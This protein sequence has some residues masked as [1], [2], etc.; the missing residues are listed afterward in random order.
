M[1][2]TDTTKT[3]ALAPTETAPQEPSGTVP[4]TQHAK[5]PSPP[6]TP[7]SDLEKNA[8]PATDSTQPRPSTSASATTPP[9]SPASTTPVLPKAEDP[10][11]DF[12]GNVDVNDDLITAKDLAR[13]DD[14]LVL[15]A[16]GESRPFKDLYKGPGVAPRQLIIFV[17]H[18][19]CGNCQ[20]YLRELSASVTPESLLALPE[21]SFITVIGCGRPELID[22]YTATTNCPF[23][24]YA[25]P[26]RKL[27]EALG[28]TRTLELGKKPAYIQSNLLVT[29][30]QSV[31]QGLSTGNK[32]LKG[33]DFK[34]VGGE[35]LFEE[36]KCVWA[37]RMR[38]T[39]DHAEVDTL[40]GV[41][42]LEEAKGV[43]R[44][45]WSHTVRS[46][47]EKEKE[48]KWGRVRAMSLGKDKEKK[49]LEKGLEKGSEKEKE[50]EKETGRKSEEVKEK[51]A[52]PVPVKT[53]TA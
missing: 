53:S 43:A 12:S 14:L 15:D 44:K 36:G 40:R 13:V 50:K 51:T 7:P 31:I 9:F 21:P 8:P 22:M 39:R 20:E 42:G 41:L 45:K 32:A 27:Y 2:S 25:D 1:D 28:M 48:S 30:V 17:R 49:G 24:I 52:V 37:H 29:S 26:T 46:A 19:F 4:T 11:L 35:F 5:P 6:S 18:F 34:Q 33:G 47:K 16:R 23:P 38:N 10:E 3:A